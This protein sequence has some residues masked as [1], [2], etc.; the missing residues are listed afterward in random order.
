MLLKFVFHLC[1][2][3]DCDDKPKNLEC[4]YDTVPYVHYFVTACDSDNTA[5]E[6]ESQTEATDTNNTDTNTEE[7][8][9]EEPKEPVKPFS[10]EPVTLKIATPWGIDYFTPRMIDPIQEQFPM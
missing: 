2:G 4:A 1:E 6:P 8:K 10:D 7:G 3:I 5:N 9:E